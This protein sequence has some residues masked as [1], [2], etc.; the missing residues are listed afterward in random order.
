LKAR[1]QGCGCEHSTAVEN[2]L[3]WLPSMVLV[4][5]LF[6]LSHVLLNWLLLLLLLLL[7]LPLL[8]TL[9]LLPGVC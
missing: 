8:L 2:L 9:L 5:S 6:S 7:P 3:L 4:P 1:L